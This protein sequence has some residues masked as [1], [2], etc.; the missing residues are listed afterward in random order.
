ME[1]TRKTEIIE[2][3]REGSRRFP[4]NGSHD[5]SAKT[6]A[7]R[8]VNGYENS[9]NVRIPARQARKSPGWFPIDEVP[10]QYQMSTILLLL[11]P[12]GNFLVVDRAATM[13]RRGGNNGKTLQLYWNPRRTNVR[14]N[15]SI[16]LQVNQG[17]LPLHPAFFEKGKEGHPSTP[18]VASPTSPTA[19]IYSC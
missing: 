16:N 8:N 6:V 9:R 10:L 11:L 13:S 15:S 3:L 5:N 14:P 7:G 4:R 12:L 1:T 19:R 2:F 17:H 18:F